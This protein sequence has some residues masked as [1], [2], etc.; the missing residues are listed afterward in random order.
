[1]ESL[2]RWGSTCKLTGLPWT[3]WVRVAS[4][5]QARHSSAVGFGSSLLAVFFVAAKLGGMVRKRAR[6]T[7]D[8]K[9]FRMV[10]VDMLSPADSSELDELRAAA[11]APLFITF[12][13]DRECRRPG[14]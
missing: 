7:P 14:P 5:W 4:L 6:A 9:I 12:W 2:N 3:S 10:R 8:A 13:P 1:M 11:S